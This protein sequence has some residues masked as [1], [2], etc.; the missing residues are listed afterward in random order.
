MKIM[1]FNI[2][3]CLDYNYYLANKIER[4]NFDVM[5]D[6]IKEVS[7]DIV[8][9]QEVRGEGR[10]DSYKEQTEILSSLANMPYHFFAKAIDF[11]DGPYGNALLSKVP[12]VSKEVITIPDPE[13]KTGT[14]WYETRCVL[15]ATL[16]GG[17][18]VLVTHVGLN[19]DE[20]E[21]AIKTITEHIASEKCIL[22]GDFNLSPE[23]P[24]LVPIREKMKDTADAFDRPK[25]S[26]PSDNP[27]KKIDYI[28]VSPD[29]EILSA[30]IPA[31][32]ASDHRPH[33]TEVKN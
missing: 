7:P 4:I 6:A 31:I 29:I 13:V 25:L 14:D 18:T 24:L 33:I 17:I 28:F 32:I 15:K 2:Q 20:K 10:V 11:A 26:C 23:D 30:D 3:H 19:R 27:D 1:T 12:I 8:G 21:N 5:A 16:E 22:M 9:L